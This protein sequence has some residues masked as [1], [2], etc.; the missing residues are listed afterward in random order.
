MMGEPWFDPSMPVPPTKG[1]NHFRHPYPPDHHPGHM[2]APNYRGRG[3]N[4]G[5]GGGVYFNDVHNMAVPPVFDFSADG[6]SN[7]QLSNSDGMS[8]GGNIMIPPDHQMHPEGST[9]QSR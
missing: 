9:M 1:F 5:E 2:G 3:G 4:R 7:S 6:H 8:A